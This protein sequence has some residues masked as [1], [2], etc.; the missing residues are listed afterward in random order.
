MDP[1]VANAGAAIVT[2]GVV[3]VVCVGVVD[4]VRETVPP[5]PPPPEEQAAKAN[6]LAETRSRKARFVLHIPLPR[7]FLMVPRER[8]TGIVAH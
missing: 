2:V 1:A 3:D 6:T 8:N 4:V 7:N 5:P